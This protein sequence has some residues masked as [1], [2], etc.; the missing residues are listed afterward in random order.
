MKSI[1]NKSYT[2]YLLF[3]NIEFFIKPYLNYPFILSFYPLQKKKL[4]FLFDIDFSILYIVCKFTDKKCQCFIILLFILIDTQRKGRENKMIITDTLYFKTRK[5]SSLSPMQCMYSYS[6]IN[7]QSIAHYLN[8]NSKQ[9][10]NYL[11]GYR[12]CPQQTA[13]KIN[14]IAE[15][16]DHERQFFYEEIKKFKQQA[17]RD[18]RQ[19]FIDLNNQL[20]NMKTNY[21]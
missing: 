2:L 10:H 3:Y 16:L 7:L 15:Q 17:N 18:L 1:D 12:Y 6:D 13:I 8:L 21:I 19:E 14:A 5:N 20:N 11:S 9:L 4:P